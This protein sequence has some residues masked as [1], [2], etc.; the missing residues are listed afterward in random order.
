M[1]DFDRKMPPQR[2]LS[3]GLPLSLGKVLLFR[4]WGLTYKN[5][6]ITLTQGFFMPKNPGKIMNLLRSI[7][8]ILSAIILG[9]VLSIG[10]DYFLEAVGIFPS[11]DEQQLHGLQTWWLY[12]IAL[13]YRCIYTIGSGYLAA[14][15][16]PYRPVFHAMIPGFIG[17]GV[18]LAGTV[19]MWDKGFQWYSI[20]LTVLTPI[21]TWTGA[22]LRTK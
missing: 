8:A 11:F 9:A 3:N 15:L 21:C 2:E 18:S 5:G 14:A 6:F 7:L 19:A 4:K 10:T 16:A 22:K 17:F 1:G 20:S 12:L 13:T